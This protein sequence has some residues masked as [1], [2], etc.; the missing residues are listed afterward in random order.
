MSKTKVVLK[1]KDGRVRVLEFDSYSEA[2]GWIHEQ[3]T[4]FGIKLDLELAEFDQ[5]PTIELYKERARYEQD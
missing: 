4:K 5:E 2:T 1:A 3:T